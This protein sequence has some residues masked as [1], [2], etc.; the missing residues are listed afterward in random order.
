MPYKLKLESL[1]V[2]GN[3]LVKLV[4]LLDD[5]NSTSTINLNKDV[6]GLYLKY[7]LLEG[8]KNC[9]WIIFF[10]SGFMF[11]YFKWTTYFTENNKHIFSKAVN[12]R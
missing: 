7:L 3:V 9:F 12:V 2:I 6:L 10:L 11:D 4:F 1:E 5:E 8:E